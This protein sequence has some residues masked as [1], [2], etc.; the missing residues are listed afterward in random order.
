MSL[1]I[2]GCFATCGTLTETLPTV[3]G[4]E[5]GVEHVWSH[6]Q[7]GCYLDLGATLSVSSNNP[8]DVTFLIHLPLNYLVVLHNCTAG[9]CCLYRAMLRAEL[10]RSLVN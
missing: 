7:S 1:H 8:P 6:S 2:Q 3:L 5:L 9:R 4:A 10:P